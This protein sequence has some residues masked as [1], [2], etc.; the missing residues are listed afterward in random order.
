MRVIAECGVNWRNF[1]EALLMIK[2]AKEAGCWAA[3]FQLF[4]EEVAPNLPKHLYLT[5]GQAEMLF[6]TG[7]HE[8]GIEVF[9]TPMFLEAVDWCE[10][11]GVNYYKIR[12]KDRNNQEL[13]D[14]IKQTK[15]IYFISM[16]LEDNPHFGHGYEQRKVL[17]CK[18]FYPCGISEYIFNNS[19]IFDGISDHTK[20][21]ELFKLTSK[22]SVLNTFEYFEKHVKLDDDC[23]ESAWSVTFEELAEVLN[24]KNKKGGEKR[25][26]AL[27]KRK[28]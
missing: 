5:H 6:D 24:N 11:I 20:D 7:K 16:E 15:K 21:L 19:I 8:V 17:F 12:F 18:P 2:K 10:A 22:F 1:E 28:M 27:K 14:R 3:K 4:T 9:F 26:W 25:K 23:I 13:I